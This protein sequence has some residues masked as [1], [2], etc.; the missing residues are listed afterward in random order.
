MAIMSLSKSVERTRGMELGLV[1]GLADFGVQ[2]VLG[3][4]LRTAQ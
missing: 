3:R 1:D 2:L 4:T